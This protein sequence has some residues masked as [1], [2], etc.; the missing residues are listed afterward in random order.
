MDQQADA[1]GERAGYRNLGGMEQGHDIPA[2]LFGRPRGEGGVEIAGDRKER[3]HDVVGLELVGVDQGAQQLVGGGEDLRGVVAVDRGGSANAVE[4]RRGSGMAHNVAALI[5]LMLVTDD[6]LAGG[7]DLVELARAAE[8]GRGDVGAAPAQA[9]PPPGSW[10]TLARALVAR[11]GVP[12]LV[13]D[14]PD[15]ALAAGA[16]GAHLGPD[17]LPLELARRIRRRGSSRRVRGHGGGGGAS[18]GRTIGV[19]VPGGSRPLRAM[20]A[21]RWAPRD[22]RRWWRSQEVGRVIAIGGVRPEDVPAVRGTGG[23]GVAVVSG[24]LGADDVE[25]ARREGK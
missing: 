10:W 18:R 1:A 16:A 22:S 24:I 12:V 8:R 7:R 20:P 6:D 14:R 21:R 15:V 19:S 2:K 9:A 13:N 4:P 25:G 23:A 3:T 11:S 17:D 5:R